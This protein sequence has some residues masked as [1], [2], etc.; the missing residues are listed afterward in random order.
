MVATASTLSSIACAIDSGMVGPDLSALPA[1]VVEHAAAPAVSA[2]TH[3]SPLLTAVTA[4]DNGDL[5]QEVA[6]DDAAGGAKDVV[7]A[8]FQASAVPLTP[9]DLPSPPVTTTGAHQALSPIGSPSA[10]ASSLRATAVCAPGSLPDLAAALNG[11][12]AQRQ[13]SA[14]RLVG[15]L[16]V[17][18]FLRHFVN[19]LLMLLSSLAQ[20]DLAPCSSSG[21]DSKQQRGWPE[22]QPVCLGHEAL[23]R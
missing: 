16:G 17:S 10:R 11:K 3:V 2:T 5:R 23:V 13:R 1:Y 22:H 14:V 7:I 4:T 18:L 8:N 19:T 20:H 15:L 21:L 6:L 12:H 9:A